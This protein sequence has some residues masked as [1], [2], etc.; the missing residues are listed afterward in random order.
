MKAVVLASGGLDSTVAAAMA[1][2]DGY[3]LYLLTIEYGQRHH[4][5]IQRAREIA[6]WL[7]AVEHKIFRFDLHEFGGSALVGSGDVPKNR[8]NHERQTGIP[9]TYVPARNTVFLSLAL[10]YAEVVD[11]SCIF[12]GAN[13][14]DYSGYP[15]CRPEF[16][17]A[18]ERVAKLGTKKGTHGDVVQIKAP[19]LFSSKTQIIQQGSALG[20]PFELTHS[21]YDPHEDG[22]ACGQCDS[23]LIRLKGFEDAGLRDPA[24]YAGGASDFSSPPL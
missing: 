1:R 14:L 18:F 8:S 3:A 16:L 2:H 7:A 12:I 6:A 11:A 4:V 5:E 22:S 23:C 21:C 10:A 13:V 20:V 24:P 17:R 15:D 19:L 9:S